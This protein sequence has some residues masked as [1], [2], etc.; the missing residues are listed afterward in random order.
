MTA[1]DRTVVIVLGMLAIIAG[2]W[3]LLVSPERKE[4]NKLNDQVA[5]ARSTLSTAEGKL[6]DARNAQH[7]YASA[8]ASIVTLG[9]AVPP[10]TE[11]PSLI[12]Q[13]EGAS[14]TRHVDFASIVAGT[15]S[16]TT[17]ASPSGTAAAAAG[18]SQMPF[19]FTFNGSYFDLE[20]LFS[21]LDRFT[22]RTST[23]TLQ[24]SGRLLTIQGVKLTPLNAEG[25]VSK[26]LELTGSITAVAYVLPGTEGLTAGATPSSPSGS[27]SSASS[28]TS[29]SSAT[30]AVVTP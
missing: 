16:S 23:G 7:Q 27:T 8:Y 13:L 29:S 1:R 3:I 9:K 26:K 12:Y 19:T 17:T 28:S 20:R 15:G 22:L 6:N 10:S 21:S 25:A 14:N 4:A 5:A 2:G 18:F 24:V 11:V 30:P